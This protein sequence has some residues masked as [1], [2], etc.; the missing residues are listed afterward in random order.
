MIS[1]GFLHEAIEKL[2]GEPLQDF[3]FSRVERKFAA[4]G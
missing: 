3:L 1:L 2:D 4:I